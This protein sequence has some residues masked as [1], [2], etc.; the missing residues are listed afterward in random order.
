MSA[1]ICAR[2]P[3][4]SAPNG[5]S[6]SSTR[7]CRG[8]RLRDRQALLHAARERARIF[9]AMRPEA[10]RLDQRVA[11]LDA[12]CGA[13]RRSGAPGLGSSRTRGRSARCRARSGA[14]T[15][16]SAGRRRRDRARARPAAARRRAGSRRASAAPGRGSGAGTCS[17]RRRM[18]R[19]PRGRCRT[20]ISRLIRSSTIWSPYS[21]QTLRNERA[22]ISAAPRHRPRESRARDEPREG[23]VHEVGQQRDPG[24][25][26]QDHVHREIAADEEDAV[27]EADVGGDRLGRD[28]EQETP[29]RATAAPPRSGAASSAAAPRGSRPA[30]SRRR[31]SAP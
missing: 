12:P 22:L 19:P 20:A 16:N 29:G 7:G 10:D 5:S 13:R 15:P 4:S 11:L 17:C 31:A 2:V 24:D 28:Q 9:V 30:R 21:T 8:E 26:G 3:G 14:E 18:A 23:E 6:S 27:A 25:V 1:C